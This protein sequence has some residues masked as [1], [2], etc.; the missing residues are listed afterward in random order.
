M[1][2][3]SVVTLSLLL[4]TNAG[5]PHT[6]NAGPPPH[7]RRP[8]L[9]ID[10]LTT[11]RVDGSYFDPST[12]LGIVFNS[13]KELL[14]ITSLDGAVLVRAV[15]KLN[16]DV[17]MVA[18]EENKFLQHSKHGDLAVSKSHEY[19]LESASS[20]HQLV[21]ILREL[22]QESHAQQLS[23]SV[24]SLLMRPEIKL[25]KDVSTNLGELGI[26]GV[27]YP[28][29]LPFFMTSLRLTST[30]SVV[31]SVSYIDHLRL[32][33]STKTCLDNCPPCKDQ[34][35]LGLCG[36]GCECW[37]WACGDCCYHKGCLYHDKC[38]REQPNS[39]ACLIPLDFSC[40]KKYKCT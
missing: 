26:T 15:E 29:I 22:P 17:R 35:C 14:T 28:S 4:Q 9:T 40:G 36:P 5:P 33:R 11:Q 10:T 34:E 20:I 7:T 31:S 25:L 32:R 39:T 23:K 19:L 3:L 1:F 16:D 21:P 37:K 18:I 38:C 24:D 12:E 2:V 8:G 13:S 27:A 6:L 30:P